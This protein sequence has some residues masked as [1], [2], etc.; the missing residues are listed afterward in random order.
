MSFTPKTMIWPDTWYCSADTLFWQL[1]IDNNMDVQYQR[2]THG[3]DGTVLFFN[4]RGS[5]HACQVQ[6]AY[7]MDKRMYS[8]VTT[9]TFL[10]GLPN[11]LWYGAL[12]TCLRRAGVPLWKISEANKRKERGKITKQL[13]IS[14]TRTAAGSVRWN[15]MELN[16][17]SRWMQRT[18]DDLWYKGNWRRKRI[19]I[20]SHN[21]LGME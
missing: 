6:V 5:A 21:L 14:V 2:C 12:L 18:V 11:F 10:D 19:R 20:K 8:H 9:R 16:G 4:V 15:K 7:R 13:E 3:N 17:Q 1:S